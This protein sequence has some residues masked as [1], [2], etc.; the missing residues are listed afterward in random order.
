MTLRPV[1]TSVG[2]LR[3]RDC[4]Y[5]DSVSLPDE[6]RVLILRGE[7]NGDLCERR[8]PGASLPFEA[9]FSGVMAIRVLELDSWSFTGE[10]SFDEV[11]E[12]SWIAE[13]GGKVTPEHRHFI[14]QTYDDVF[15]IVCDRVEVSI[16]EPDP[17]PG[18]IVATAGNVL[19][20]ALLVLE[21]QG[22][23]VQHD[24]EDAKPWTATRRSQRI[25]ADDPLQLLGLAAMRDVRGRVW[26]ASDDQIA[27]ALHRFHLEA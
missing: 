17:P 23:A 18:E 24:S 7:I 2:L 3:G 8:A 27:D 26:R 9:C 21:Q 20:P 15:D 13:L 11:L 22:W 14:V 6:V 10:T 25:M 12:S 16:V 19:V 4:I 5:L 1:N